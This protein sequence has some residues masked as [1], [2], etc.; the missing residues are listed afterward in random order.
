M[1]RRQEV[2]VKLKRQL[3]KSQEKSMSFASKLTR[4]ETRFYSA[5]KGGGGKDK[6]PKEE[7]PPKESRKEAK[8][9]ERRSSSSGGGGGGGA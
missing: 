8:E 5:L 6:G 1:R 3:V 4:L 2:I 7:K 9:R